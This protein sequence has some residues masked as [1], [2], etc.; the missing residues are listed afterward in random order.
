MITKRACWTAVLTLLTWP[1]A[2]QDSGKGAN[3]G[4]GQLLFNNAC[5]TCHTVEEGDNRLGPSLHGI[6]G[7][8]AGALPNYGYSDSMK[9]ADI[10]WDEKTL[11]RFIASPDSVVAGN[12]MKPFG[13]VAS[14]EDRAK[15]I[16]Y[17]R[18]P[19]SR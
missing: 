18:T 15:I 9:H 5:R 7:R 8:K 4:D 14:A 13:G 11:D 1:A 17:L 6:V 16:T 10:T 3:A 19:G 12:N 2:A